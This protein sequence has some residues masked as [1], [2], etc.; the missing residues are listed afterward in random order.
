[1][2]YGK[3]KIGGGDIGDEE[4]IVDILE[5][6]E[7][8]IGDE[9]GEESKETEVVGLEDKRK[10]GIATLGSLKQHPRNSAFR[11]FIEGWY[12]SYFDPNAARSLPLAGPQKHLN[13]NGDN[14]GNFVQ[15]MEREHPRRFKTILSRIAEKIPGIDK[16][17]T[18]RT[19]DGR[20]I[21]QFNDKGFQDPF[22]AQQMS[23]G[24]LKMFAYLL[25][26]ADPSPP[27]FL[28]IEEPKTVCTISFLNPSPRNFV[29][30]PPETRMVY[31]SPLR[32]TS[33]NSW[34][35]WSQ[36]KFGFWRRVPMAFQRFG[37]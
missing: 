24:T 35:H 28:C 36:T 12:L 14:L 9:A 10:L 34:T 20:L 22:F 27:P 18:E 11:R 17:D 7:K 5:L 30:M 31:R 2:S 1:M 8:L 15:F 13:S 6:L 32:P 29:N 26:L 16:I 19:T 25:L 37:G 3:A 21:L 23:D 33:H 4:E